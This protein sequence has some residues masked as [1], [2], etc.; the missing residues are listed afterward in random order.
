MSINFST[1]GNNAG[2]N[3]LNNHIGNNNQNFEDTLAR[4]RIYNLDNLEH[5]L[6]AH[7]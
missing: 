7:Q 2:N 4:P 3:S 1:I 5:E 6:N